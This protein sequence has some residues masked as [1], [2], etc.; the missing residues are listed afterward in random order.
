MIRTYL[1]LFVLLLASCK[2]EV[3][4]GENAGSPIVK[5]TVQKT[6]LQ[7]DS[8]ALL[9]LTKD[10]Y[11]WEENRQGSGDFS[12][13]DLSESDTFY[14]ALDRPAHQK[15]L[16]EMERSGLF[17]GSFLNTYNRIADRVD[18]EL[19]SGSIVWPVGEL[20]PFGNG[21]SPWCNCQDFPDDYQ[22]KFW[23]L[24]L[25]VKDNIATYDWGFG[26]GER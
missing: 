7:S 24:R 6:N 10:L 8:L 2:N 15:K 22:N 23:I 13:L 5:D 20:P 25:E 3:P 17:T 16:Q 14:T 9:Q 12:P 19:K 21:A 4:A 11:E 1:L 26:R 18:A